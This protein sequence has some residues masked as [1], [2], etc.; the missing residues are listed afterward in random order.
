MIRARVRVA[1]AALLSAT[2]AACSPRGGSNDH[3]PVVRSV[4][5]ARPHRRDLSRNMLVPGTVTAYFQATLLAQVAGY[6]KAVNFDKGDPVRAGDL[7]AEIE[8]PELVAA[9]AT[10][11]A[12]VEQARADLGRARAAVTA[13]LAQEAE[14]RANVAH[15]E[16]LAQLEVSIHERAKALRASGDVSVQ[17]LEV[18][19]GRAAAAVAEKALAA[20]KLD[21]ARAEVE[22]ARSLVSVAEAAVDAAASALAEI[23]ATLSYAQ[24]RAPFDGVVTARFLDPGA[25]VQ[26]ATRSDSAQPIVSVATRGRVRIDFE[27]PEG[28]IAFVHS[29]S[30][31]AVTTAAYPGRTFDGTLTRV[32]SALHPDTRTELCEAELSNADDALL[33]GLYVSVRIVLEE[34]R[35]AVIVP[36]EAIA[37]R[38]EGE[39]FAYVV[40][41]KRAHKKAV[42]KGWDFGSFVEVLEGI[43]TEDQVVLGAGDLA[44]EQT[45]SPHPSAW[46][47]DEG[48]KRGDDGRHERHGESVEGLP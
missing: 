39:T 7:V 18:A 13:A 23:D 3:A 27:L 8:V 6:V 28:E 46:S 41:G 35:Q 24:V 40:E 34:H 1:F 19:A 33:P 30:R 10:R 48:P 43:S 5:V 44:D 16:A 25:L 12:R 9:R 17:D 11:A 38:R 21:A 4:K 31:I 45:I 47:P 29:G 26:R 2:S 22:K 32:A 20:A 36:P 42:K 37:E 14:A 15:A